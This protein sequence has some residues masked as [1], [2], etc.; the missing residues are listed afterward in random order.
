MLLF[1]ALT[2]VGI[3]AWIR[4]LKPPPSTDS[5]PVNDEITQMGARPNT[6]SNAPD[7]SR[8]IRGQVLKPTGEPA[9]D[10]VVS[11]QSATSDET[12]TIKTNAGGTFRFENLEMGLYVIEADLEGYGPAQVI[13]VA[14]GGAALRLTLLSGRELTGQLRRKDQVLNMGV[15]QVG[16]PGIFPQRSQ[17]VDASGNFRV[18]GLRAGIVEA[19]AMSPGFSSGFVENIAID[20]EGNARHDFEMLHAPTV[21][22]RLTDR[23][24]GDVIDSG[25]I[26][27]AARPLHVLAVSTQIFFGE[28]T[29][30]FL[31]PG[32]YWMRVRAPGYL[33]RDQRFWVTSNGGTL[34]IALSQGA[35]MSGRV[36]DQAG[37]PLQGVSL[38]AVVEDSS[39]G[40]FDMKNGIFETFHGL[41]RP[42]GTT[43]WWPSSSYTTNAE[44]RFTVGGIPAGRAMLVANKDGFATGLSPNIQ[45]QNDNTYEDIRI[46]LER[47]RALRGRVEN[48]SGGPIAGAVVTAVPAALPAWVSGRSL[49]TDGTGAFT[50][51]GL[52]SKVRLTV[53]HPRYGVVQEALSLGENGLD[54]HI[55]RLNQGA[56]IRYSGRILVSPQGSSLGARIWYLRRDNNL[57]VCFGIA[58]EKGNFEARDCSA[59]A[60]RFI[61]FKPGYAPLMGDAPPQGNAREYVLRQGGELDIVAQR[62]SMAVGVI[63]DF[64]LPD[65]AWLVEPFV[66]ERWKRHTMRLLAPG[67]YLV[68]CHAEGFAPATIRVEVSEGKRAEAVCPVPQ[69]VASQEFAVLDSQGAP[70]ADAVIWVDGL[71]ARPTQMRSG[72]RGRFVLEGMPERWVQIYAA[73]EDWGAGSLALQ[74][75]KDPQETIAIRLQDPIGGQDTSATQ[76]LLASWGLRVALDRR[77]IIVDDVV[78]NTPA[79]SVGFRRG[80]KLLWIRPESESRLSV[81]VRRRSDVVTH[82]LVR[83]ER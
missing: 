74:L 45:I 43:F 49:V 60:E 50:F 44:G 64:Y 28:A 8:T 13:G 48:A 46:V 71:S 30:D 3:D 68:T 23:G 1:T 82:I 67:R 25:V 39:G 38:R 7:E 12:L 18:A 42:D 14:P 15:V 27:I 69:R 33:P 56:T 62:H 19:I 78:R 4:K 66:V 58:D 81:G 57:P 37:N 79:E 61:A 41:A 9:N 54:N 29:I 32:E 21:E 36:V 35:Q 26:T 51:Q 5:L 83:G 76:T 31:P 6:P 47:G 77:A 53:R 59:L 65:E 55:V 63:P 11:L 22:I 52:P 72:P 17:T 73:H 75:P 16:G 80:D 10:A 20:S 40:R 70:V 24:T 34:D 2:A